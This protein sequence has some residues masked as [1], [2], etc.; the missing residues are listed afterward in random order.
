MHPWQAAIVFSA[1]STPQSCIEGASTAKHAR[2]G[3]LRET[4]TATKPENRRPPCIF[5]ARRMSETQRLPPTRTY[6]LDCLV[7]VG[8][9]TA[10][11]RCAC[12]HHRVSSSPTRWPHQLRSLL[13]STTIL[14][15]VHLQSACIPSQRG[16]EP[17]S[18]SAT[19]GVVTQRLPFED[20]WHTWRLAEHDG[21][22]SRPP[23][24]PWSP[25]QVTEE[26]KRGDHQ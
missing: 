21:M 3:W 4:T 6:T 12:Q 26:R 14:C 18:S 2:H 19:Q 25:D 1:L 20:R 22:R 8:R 5:P 23:T 24:Q 13:A 11:R 10:H 16:A 9:V 15:N 17:H 7:S